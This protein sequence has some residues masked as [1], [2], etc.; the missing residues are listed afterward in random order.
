MAN[1][2]IWA[3]E[4]DLYDGVVEFLVHVI[5]RPKR[6]GSGVHEKDVDAAFGFPDL[7]H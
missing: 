1:S 3:L 5:Q 7:R 6:T 2:E 4:I